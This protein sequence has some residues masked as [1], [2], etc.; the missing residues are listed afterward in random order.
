[1]KAL[2]IRIFAGVIALGAIFYFLAC[3]PATN[4]NQNQ[5]LGV[6]SNQNAATGN[7]VDR[8]LD[9]P[10]EYEAPPPGGHGNGIKKK[11]KDKMSDKLKRQLKDAENPTGTFTIEIE[12]PVGVNYY[13]AYVAGEVSGDDRLKE[14]SNILN[15]F[16]DKKSCVRIAMFYPGPVLTAE[17][18]DGFEWAACEYP[19]QTCPSGVCADICPGLDPI[20]SPAP[21]GNSNANS[22]SNANGNRNGNTRN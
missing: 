9:E 22:N 15:D 3:A 21:T 14:L 12:K 5:N 19:K 18:G 8:D 10:C 4:Q 11:M 2:L 13:V 6:A 17:R 1:M 16:Q 7:V 20:P